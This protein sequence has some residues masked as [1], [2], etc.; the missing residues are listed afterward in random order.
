ME[1]VPL[2]YILRLMAMND[3]FFHFLLAQVSTYGCHVIDTLLPG[4]TF[5][6]LTKDA[7]RCAC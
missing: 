5:L 6:A 7:A 2:P 1:Y 3:I 4:F